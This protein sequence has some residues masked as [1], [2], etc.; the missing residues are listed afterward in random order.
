MTIAGNRPGLHSVD[1]ES[2]RE[3]SWLPPT[4]GY[5]LSPR[6]RSLW[7]HPLVSGDPETVHAA[8]ISCADARRGGRA[9]HRDYEDYLVTWAAGRWAG[10]RRLGHASECCTTMRTVAV[11]DGRFLTSSRRGR[12]AMRFPWTGER[13]R[14]RHR[15]N[16]MMSSACAPAPN[17]GATPGSFPEAFA[18]GPRELE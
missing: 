11:S 12:C 1:A 13:V 7:W 5:R 3:I 10:S 15:R 9:S 6:Q 14:R 17:G 4:C 8:G 18:A 2:V 16:R